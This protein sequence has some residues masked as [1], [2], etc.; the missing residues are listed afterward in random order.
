MG[1]PMDGGSAGVRFASLRSF[2]TTFIHE[3]GVAW[4]ETGEMEVC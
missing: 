3:H 1:T 2:P 4:I